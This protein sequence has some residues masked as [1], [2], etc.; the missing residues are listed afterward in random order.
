MG[1]KNPNSGEIKPKNGGRREECIRMNDWT[2][3]RVTDLNLD[4]TCWHSSRPGLCL[5]SILGQA[6]PFSWPDGG[7]HFSLRSAQVQVQWEKV[8]IS[9]VLKKSLSVSLA[10]HL[11]ISKPVSVDCSVGLTARPSHTPTPERGWPVRALRSWVENG[12]EGCSSQG[13]RYHS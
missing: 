2:V 4:L 11:L 12:G 1:H 5:P 6:F 7:T 9:V 8:P 10:P 13:N 3:R